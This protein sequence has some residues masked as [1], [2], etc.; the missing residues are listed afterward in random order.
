MSDEDEAAEIDPEVRYQTQS[1]LAA[2]D[3]I[4]LLV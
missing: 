1:V 4:V 2:V 3:S